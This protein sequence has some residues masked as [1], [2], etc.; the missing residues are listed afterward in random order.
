M[1]AFYHLVIDQGATL[2]E[3]FTYRD[4]NNAIVDLTGY[5]ARSQIRTSYSASGTVLSATSQAGTVSITAATGL[6][7]FN[8]PAATTATLTPGNYV[9]DLEIIDPSGI[10]TRLV[11]GTCTVTPEVTK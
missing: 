1:A 8:V 9:W 2:R 11:G 10:V 6:I 5:S 4:S 7:A 3:S